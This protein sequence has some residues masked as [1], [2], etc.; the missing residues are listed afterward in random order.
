MSA[1]P[2]VVF[3]A[4]TIWAISQSAKRLM[5]VLWILGSIVVVLG[6]MWVLSLA[7]PYGAEVLGH[8]AAPLVLFIPAIVGVGHAR[9]HR[10]KV[11]LSNPPVQH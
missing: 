4:G 10:R 1:L 3:L 6:L 9:A 7:M 11:P 8:A 2:L 5:T